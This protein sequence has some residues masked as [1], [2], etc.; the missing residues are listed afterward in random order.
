MTSNLINSKWL[1]DNLANPDLIILDASQTDN[2]SGKE[3]EFANVQIKGARVFDIKN[4]FSELGSQ[5]PNTFPSSEQ[6]E[7][8]CQ[9][10]GIN[11]NSKIVVYD[12]LGIFTSPR[13]WWMFKTFGHKNISVLDGGLPDWVK[14]EYETEKIERSQYKLGDFKAQ[15]QSNKVK[16]IN[17]IKQNIISEKCLVVDARSAGR[18]KG[19]TPE[20][21]TGLRGGN[22]PKSVNLPFQVVLENGKFKSKD[23]LTRLFSCIEESEKPL[24]FSC[25]SG[26]TACIILF[27]HHLVSE[28]IE[29]VYDGSWTEWGTLES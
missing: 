15:L 19:I 28:N 22:I 13:V 20:P 24:I 27:A 11:K 26:I 14:K 10:L 18:F 23:K 29:F 17:D 3:P 9:E 6:F 16:Y 8:G 1:N 12:N 5:F 7:K 21:R 4:D 25:G 2:K